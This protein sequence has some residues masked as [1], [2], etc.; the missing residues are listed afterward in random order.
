VLAHRRFRHY[1]RAARIWKAR[2]REAFAPTIK[3][4]DGELLTR[5]NSRPLSSAVVGL[6]AVGLP[7]DFSNKRGRAAETAGPMTTNR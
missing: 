7:A 5:R 6:G 3:D 4:F 1:S 2:M